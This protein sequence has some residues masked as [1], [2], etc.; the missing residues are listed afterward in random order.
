MTIYQVKNW[1]LFQHYKDRSP[2]WIRLHRK[3]LDNHD[4]HLLPALAAKHLPLVWLIASES[5]GLLPDE[6]QLAFR[7]RLQV[8]DVA[9]I[10]TALAERSFLEEARA[11][12]PI[13]PKLSTP[14]QAAGWGSR[15]IPDK[16]KVKVWQRDNG[17]CQ[18]CGSVDNIEYDHIIPVSKGGQPVDSNLQLLCRSCNRRKRVSTQPE[19]VATQSQQQDLLRRTPETEAETDSTEAETERMPPAAVVTKMPLTDIPS[20]WKQ[21][22]MEEKGWPEHVV[23]DVWANFRDYWQNGKGKNT[24]RSDWSASWGTWF[25]KENINVKGPQHGKH[26]GFEKQDYYAGTAGFDVT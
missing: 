24:R 7:L 5:D 10:I 22:A 12:Q 6:G 1:H 21:K 18:Q 2:P 8:E 3:L 17:K 4:Y 14:A 16:T 26:T 25:R 9:G 20:D 13:K 11:S 23:M 19:R 15:H